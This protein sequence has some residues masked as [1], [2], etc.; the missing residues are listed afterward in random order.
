[1]LAVAEL[2]PHVGLSSAC[3]A[4]ALNRGFVYRDRVRR[5]V[6]ESRRVSRARP[7]WALSIAE[8]D[9]LL[10]L[11]DSERFADV[12]PAAVFATLLDE[13]RYHDVAAAL[14]RLRRE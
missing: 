7:R 9:L 10:G 13:G 3:H 1:M 5:R 12:A 2:T 4:F 11:L 14:D 8:Q 6:T